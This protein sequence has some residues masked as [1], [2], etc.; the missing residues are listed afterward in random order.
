MTNEER[1]KE[2]REA[3]SVALGALQALNAANSTGVNQVVTMGYDA[4]EVTKDK[5][6]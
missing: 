3:L 5:D 1:V 4:L 6:E 2:L